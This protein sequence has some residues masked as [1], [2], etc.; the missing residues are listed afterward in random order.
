MILGDRQGVPASRKTSLNQNRACGPTEYL[1]EPT[2]L[3][4]Y[5]WDGR[6]EGP[7]A[8]RLLDVLQ[9]VHWQV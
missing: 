5:G 9:L 2:F 7:T 6:G 1:A 4:S 8:R 3:V